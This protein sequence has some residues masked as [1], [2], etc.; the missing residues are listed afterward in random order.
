MHHSGSAQAVNKQFVPHMFTQKPKG[1][2]QPKT[3]NS[4]LMM[5]PP[6]ELLLICR[7]TMVRK[8]F[9]S[10]RAG[11]TRDQRVRVG[12]AKLFANGCKEQWVVW[13]GG[14]LKGIAIP[15][16]VGIRSGVAV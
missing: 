10:C 16:I 7:P 4:D 15:K 2:Y 8:T 6:S 1:L 11:D 14:H 9:G 13:S 5:I 3:A 12:I